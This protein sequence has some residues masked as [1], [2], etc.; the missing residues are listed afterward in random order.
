KI[1][2]LKNWYVKASGGIDIMNV[3]TDLYRTNNVN[4]GTGGTGTADISKRKNFL[5]E[6]TTTYSKSIGSLNLDLLAGYSFQKEI[7]GAYGIA[8]S[9][10]PDDEIKTLNAGTVISSASSSTSERALVSY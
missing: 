4:R 7:R 9:G 1:Q 3:T 10:F 6:F 2:P 8:K 5:S